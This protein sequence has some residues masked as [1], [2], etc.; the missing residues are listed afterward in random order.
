[1]ARNN[2]KALKELLKKDLKK[3]IGNFMSGTAGK[4]RDDLTAEASQSIIDFY[5]DYTPIYYHRH[6]Y[7][8]TKNSYKKYYVNAHGTI[9]HGGVKLTPDKMADIYQDPVSEVFDA[10][11]SGFHGVSSM[12]VS[13]YTFEVTPVMKPSPIERLYMKRDDIVDNIDRYIEYGQ[14]KAK[15]QSYSVINVR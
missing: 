2:T 5:N 13:P 14:K 10:V 15:K 6:Y 9:Y 3:Y 12:F 11:Y 8:F 7:N 4:I 1:M